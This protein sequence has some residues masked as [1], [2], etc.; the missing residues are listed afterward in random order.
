M[1]LVL[2]LIAVDLSELLRV[3]VSLRRD[4]VTSIAVPHTTAQQLADL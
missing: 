3:V 4:L 2:E 1:F